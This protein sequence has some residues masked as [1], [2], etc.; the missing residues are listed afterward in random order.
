[1]KKLL[2]LL[3]F[4]L[5][6]FGQVGIPYRNLNG[7]TTY[8]KPTGGLIASLTWNP[9]VL[10]TANNAGLR[11]IANYIW[12]INSNGDGQAYKLGPGLM[13]GTSPTGERQLTIDF[14]TLQMPT[15]GMTGFGVVQFYISDMPSINRISDTLIKICPNCSQVAPIIFRYVPPGFQITANQYSISDYQYNLGI[16]S[17][18]CTI[19]VSTKDEIVI[20]G[21]LFDRMVA[22][23]DGLPYRNNID[24]EPQ[25]GNCWMYPLN[26]QPD[27]PISYVGSQSNLFELFKYTA[28]GGIWRTVEFLN[29]YSLVTMPNAFVQLETMPLRQ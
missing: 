12:G 16:I 22:F 15:I 4:S 21:I 3:L 5:V 18:G 11:G 26:P 6:S 13:W 25:N 2:L 27:Q 1:M 23:G 19:P 20:I 29:R 10:R 17:T 24:V 28:S 9:P 8:L 7:T 14:T